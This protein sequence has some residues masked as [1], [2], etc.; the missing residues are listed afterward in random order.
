ML[1]SFA[2]HVRTQWPLTLLS[3]Y[4]AYLVV[5][6]LREAVGVFYP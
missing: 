3:C 6:T 2:D 4:V 5:D 1:R